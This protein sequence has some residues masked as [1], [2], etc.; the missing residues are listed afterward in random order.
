MVAGVNFA[1]ERG[2]RIA[3]RGGGHNWFGSSLRDGGLL[4]DLGSLRDISIQADR[5]EAIVQP[6]VTGR[7]L[8]QKLQ[9][10][11]LCFPIGHC[12]SVPLSGF[13]LSGGLGWNSL[14]WGPACFSLISAD[15]VTAE[16]KVVAA[17][18][19]ENSDLYWAVRGAGSGFFG[20][21]VRFRIA[22]FPLPKA[23]LTSTCLF[24]IE[25]TGEASQWASELRAKL[26]SHVELSVFIGS[27]PKA[28]GGSDPASSKYVAVTATAFCDS[29]QD[30]KSTLAPL[31]APPAQAHCQRQILNE[32][33]PYDSLLNLG[34]ELWPEDH[35]YRADNFWSNEPPS[36][37]LPRIAN[38][39][40]EAPGRSY[41]LCLPL[42]PPTP[43]TPPLPDAAFSMVGPTFNACYTIWKDA[44]EGERSQAWYAE[45]VRTLEPTTI[46]HYVGETNIEMNP[47]RAAH[48]FSPAAWKRLGELREKY[49]PSGLFHTYYGQD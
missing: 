40:A 43:Q 16:G 44:R 36:S 25:S 32:P 34:A 1:R 24:S 48:S 38:L 41:F 42:P 26:P 15:V 37:V 5:T 2:L 22:L 46:G 3:I 14:N 21:V 27:I 29:E 28:L 9:P 47:S 33:T 17:S 8:I 10:F 31:G 4:I 6:A 49:D 20:V 30:A 39:S 19:Q 23:I 12:P 13:I 45:A 18:S 35:F 7:E 11:G